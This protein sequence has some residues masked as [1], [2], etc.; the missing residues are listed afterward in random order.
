MFIVVSC[1]NYS[2]HSKMTMFGI[3]AKIP[4]YL[5]S[6]LP[7]LITEADVE[8]EFS[9]QKIAYVSLVKLTPT[10]NPDINQVCIEVSGWIN[11]LHR[12]EFVFGSNKTINT[13]IGK[14]YAVFSDQSGYYLEPGQDYSTIAQDI[15]KTGQYM[16]F[17]QSIESPLCDLVDV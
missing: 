15:R 4:A 6:Y 8:A 10:R 1:I 9:N 16:E 7:S 5:Y 11:S 14:F 12:H 13:N 2:K 17:Q 3:S